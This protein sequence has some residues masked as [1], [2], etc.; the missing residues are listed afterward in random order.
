MCQ[1]C[2]IVKL[3]EDH[4]NFASDGEPDP[5]AKPDGDGDGKNVSWLL[6]GDGDENALPG[7]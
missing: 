5:R 1:K 4:L 6:N 3:W 7:G 2:N